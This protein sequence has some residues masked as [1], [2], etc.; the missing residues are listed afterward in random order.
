MTQTPSRG[1]SSKRFM[2]SLS[3]VLRPPL[4]IARR[5]SKFFRFFRLRQD[6]EDFGASSAKSGVQ[7]GSGASRKRAP[8]RSVDTRR[9]TMIPSVTYACHTVGQTRTAFVLADAAAASRFANR[10]NTR[11]PSVGATGSVEPSHRQVGLDA[12]NVTSYRGS[13]GCH[14]VLARSLSCS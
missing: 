11:S 1:A 9:K 6:R 13:N 2:S 10:E 8:K 5:K 12:S 4:A 3:T 7:S 14:V